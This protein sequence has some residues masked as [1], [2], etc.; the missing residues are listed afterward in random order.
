ML[1]AMFSPAVV[2]L[3]ADCSGPN[4]RLKRWDYSGSRE[5]GQILSAC[6]CER[7]VSTIAQSKRMGLGQGVTEAGIKMEHG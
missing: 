7:D 2:G 1:E 3:E 4:S 5:A 6:A